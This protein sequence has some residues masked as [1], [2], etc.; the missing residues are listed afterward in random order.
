MSPVACD[1]NTGSPGAELQVP[2]RNQRDS[3]PLGQ[4]HIQQFGREGWWPTLPYFSHC[5]SGMIL[6]LAQAVFWLTSFLGMRIS[7]VKFCR[8]HSARGTGG[9]KI[10]FYNERVVVKGLR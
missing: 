3:G 8:V 10:S 5:V 6:V 9:R 7:N 1:D 2:S 4:G